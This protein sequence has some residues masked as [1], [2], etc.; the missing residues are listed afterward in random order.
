VAL[1]FRA[2]GVGH[3]GGVGQANVACNRSVTMRVMPG[4]RSPVGELFE[5]AQ[6]LER[7]TGT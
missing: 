2:S 6:H 7:A 1:R 3:V 4:E 5:H